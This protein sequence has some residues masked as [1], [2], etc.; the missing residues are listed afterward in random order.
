[1][2]IVNVTPDSFSD[3]GLFHDA[4]AALAHGLLLASEGADI[5]DIGGE[6]TRPGHQPVSA[7]EESSRVLPVLRALKARTQVPLSIDTMKPTVAE[8]AIAAG[9]SILNDVWGFRRDRDM[10]RVAADTGVMVVL[11]H[12]RELDEPDIDIVADVLDGLRRSIDIALAAGL[13]DTKIVL[14][15]G[16]GFGKTHEQNLVLIRHMPQLRAI[17]FPILLGVSRK[18]FVG[19]VTGRDKPVDR[20]AGTLAAGL[21]GVEYGA[22][23]LRVHDVAPHVDALK[24]RAAILGAGELA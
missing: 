7:E 19:R 20:L 24:M 8:A 9:A 3:G 6:S 1:M 15:P 13:A 14:D 5:L 18:R 17:G 23:I 11:M 4:D 22:N 21:L 10:A 2:G 16:C 12:N